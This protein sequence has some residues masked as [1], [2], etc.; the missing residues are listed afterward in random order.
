LI[1]VS[2]HLHQ[3]RGEATDQIHGVTTFYNATV[4]DENYKVVY[5]PY[6]V[7]I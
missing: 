6:V 7:E 4:V 5:T 1:H 2:G 3:G